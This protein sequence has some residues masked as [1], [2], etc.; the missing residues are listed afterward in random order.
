MS[1]SD[2]SGVGHWKWQRVSSLALIPFTLWLMWAGAGLASA[3]FE[4]ARAF[5]AQPTQALI[6][7]MMTALVAYH[8]QAGVQ[9]VCEDYVSHPW[10][11]VL[12]W[13]TR[14]GV[15]V[16]T[17]LMAWAMFGLVEGVAS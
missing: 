13:V 4:Q 9:V 2:H 14:I 8:A 1:G 10:Q 7:V 15:I 16:G 17:V 3:D 6:A 12:I 11:Q 5:F